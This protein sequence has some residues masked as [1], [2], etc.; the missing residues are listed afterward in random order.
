MS[1]GFSA[2][3]S[4]LDATFQEIRPDGSLAYSWSSVG[5]VAPAEN[6]NWTTVWLAYPGSPTPVWDM[7]HINS[8]APDGDG[9]LISTRHADAIYL[10]RASDGAIE[11]KLGGT[12]TPQS[13]TITNGPVSFSG[14]HDARVLPDGTI[15]VHDNGTNAG[16]PPRVLR[17]SINTATRTA[18]LTETVTDPAV[19]ASPCCGSASLLPD[20]DWVIDWGGTQVTDELAPDGSPVL[21][22]TL[23]APYFSYRTF[24][25]L[26]G[27]L[28]LSALES[29]M[30]AMNPRAPSVVV[31]GGSP[32]PPP[33]LA[34]VR[35]L[36]VHPFRFVVVGRRVGGR[37]V[38]LQRFNRKDRAC[39]RHASLRV[40]FELNRAASVRFVVRRALSGRITR[41]GCRRATRANH[42]GRHCT[43][44]IAVP[45][46]FTH[47]GHAGSNQFDWAAGVGTRRLGPG[48]YRLT[49]SPIP[50]G[51]SSATTAFVLAT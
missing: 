12:P 23:A 31:G 43:L 26:P 32:P 14:Q 5:R 50:S 51:A 42:R 33:A 18:T 24:P 15:S 13:L 9:F 28:S 4:V 37:C 21:R 41:A 48:S 40:V 20:G 49:A 39:R 1:L 22:L 16:R 6:V 36:G 10:V 27:Q 19:T 38:A 45:G 46:S 11:W 7:Q 47:R 8:V 34:A 2:S 25:I 17:F 44:L 3:S 29:G 35:S 30:D